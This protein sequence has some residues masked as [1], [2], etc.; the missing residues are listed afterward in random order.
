MGWF[1]LADSTGLI[2]Q[3]KFGRKSSC[4]LHKL[5]VHQKK[6]AVLMA[7][8]LMYIISKRDTQKKCWSA[9]ILLISCLCKPHSNTQLFLPKSRQHV[10]IFSWPPTKL[11]RTFEKSVGWMHYQKIQLDLSLEVS[12]SPYYMTLYYWS[13]YTSLLRWIVYLFYLLTHQ[14]IQEIKRR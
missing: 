3:E 9:H 12:L 10:S 2:R 8:R 13:T 6:W 5:E 7:W 11:T 4:F 14:Y 1:K